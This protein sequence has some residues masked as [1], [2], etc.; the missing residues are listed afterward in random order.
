MSR[1][2]LMLLAIFLYINISSSEKILKI[3]FKLYPA[4]EYLKNQTHFLTKMHMTQLAVELSIGTP[5]QKFNCSIHLNIFYSLFLEHNISGI[6]FSS[7]Y[8]KSSQTYNIIENKSYYFGE[9]FD[10]AEIFSD[11]LQISDGNKKIIDHK[12]TLLL[13]DDLGYD[14]PNE[15]YA[16]GLIGLKLKKEGEKKQV[17]ENRFI[18]KIKEYGLADTETFFFDFNENGDKGYFIIGEDLFNNDNYLKINAGKVKISSY[19]ENI[20]WCFNFDK[21][22]FGNKEIKYVE[23]ALIRTENGLIIG[24]Y[25]YNKIISNYFTNETK[26][27]YSTTFM[28]YATFKYYYCDENFDENKMEDLTFELKLIGYNFTLSP[29]DLFYKKDGKKYYKII[30]PFYTVQQYWYFNLDFLRKYKLH[31]DYDKKLIYIPIKNETKE[32][33]INR[34]PFSIFNQTYFWIIIFMGIFIVVLIVFIVIYLKKYPRKKRANELDDDDYEY[35]KKTDPD[36]IN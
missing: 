13:I 22:Y 16:P 7:Y 5:P 23:N 3:P 34:E 9:D 33:I 32:D 19:F 35:T 4:Y 26:C 11:N 29:K 31:F 25:E 10:Q 27:N 1:E 12:F 28:G 30:F 2:L 18:Y 6:V 17:N 8:N 21:V 14:V 24:P 36:E 15:F 20:D